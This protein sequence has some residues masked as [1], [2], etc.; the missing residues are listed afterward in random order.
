VILR[1]TA[2][3]VRSRP[4]LVIAETRHGFVCA[5]AGVDASNAPGADT[6]VLLPVDPDASARALHERLE[7][8]VIV[9]D[10]FGRAWRQGTTDVAIGAAG[11][12]V[13][14]ARRRIDGAEPAELERA[15]PADRVERLPVRPLSVGALHR[16]LR[17]R[18]G[19]PFARQTLLR[20]HERSGG[21]PFFALELA[22]VLDE[23]PDPLQPLPV[24]E[25]LEELV[26][27]RVDELPARTREA[28]ALASALGTPSTSLLERAGV[29]ADVLEPALRSRVIER[30]DGSVL[31]VR[32]V[33]RNGWG[34]PGGLINR[35]EDIA[36]CGRREVLEE[37]GLPVELVGEPA[38]VVDARPQRVD[39]IFRARPA[40]GVHPDSARPRSAGLPVPPR[41]GAHWWVT[42]PARAVRARPNRAITRRMR[43]TLLRGS[44]PR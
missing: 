6:V 4:P 41:S 27:A 43:S 33:Y 10:S 12:H 14:L 11:V 23:V 19:K 44:M 42:G 5:S 38:V 17:G 22:R 37:I 31:L 28:L 3:V 29:G 32:L 20:I 39:V 1:E 9:S 24:P 30:D 16:L 36:T 7:V 34:L 21:N 40:H 15:L 35:R 25:T 13:L 18:V 26:R 8:A 2:R